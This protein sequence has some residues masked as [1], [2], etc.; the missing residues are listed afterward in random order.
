MAM[1][2]TLFDPIEHAILARYF[3]LP[4]QAG[5]DPDEH[6][7]ETGY[8]QGRVR[9]CNEGAFSN[10]VARLVLYSVQERLPQWR[11]AYPDGK[12]VFGRAYGPRR[13]QRVSLLPRLIVS[14]NWCNS[15]PGMD[16]P[17]DYRVSFVPGY[18]RYVVTGSRDTDDI[19][20]YND[21]SLGHFGLDEDVVEG[22][23]RCLRTEWEM[24]VAAQC[25]R[26]ETIYS[27]GGVVPGPR[28]DAFL[29]ELW[30]STKNEPEEELDADD[31]DE[32]APASG[33]E[34]EGV[35]G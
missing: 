19:Y 22:C 28:L 23:I 7:N 24:C 11:A 14:L 27:V 18:D 30:P 26:P 13:G 20:G 17:A 12:V 25:D 3:D 29:E 5:I 32:V 10:A 31:E 35:R 1:G 33:R 6:V 34:P 2:N 8:D 16:W 4:R 15:G 9:L 21:T